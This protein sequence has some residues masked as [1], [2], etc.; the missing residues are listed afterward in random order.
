M[1]AERQDPG[2]P[3]DPGDPTQGAALGDEP[4]GPAAGPAPHVW[5]YW[6]D[7]PGRGCPAYLLLVPRDRPAPPGRDKTL[8][9]L[10]EH[11]VF[12]WLPDLD[13]KVWER[14][15]VPAQRADYARTRLVYRYGGLWIDA[16][17]IAMRRLDALDHYLDGHELASW[18]KDIRGR[19]FNNLF[20]AP[21]GSTLVGRWIEN[22]DRVLAGCE[23]WNT[24]GWNDIG[25]GAFFPLM[26]EADY[27]NMPAPE[28]APVLWFAWR[29][30][31]SPYQSPATSPG[32]VAGHGDAVEQGH[33]ARCSPAKS[34]D[35]VLGAPMLLSRLLRIALGTSTLEAELDWRTR[36]S[37]VSDLRYGPTGRSI[38][39]RLRR[40]R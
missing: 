3:P 5:M 37:P 17:C 15:K 10:D 31:L 24:L 21:A 13:R 7:L 34:S 40:L 28:V 26:R 29:R 36:L 30:F 16:D 8:H 18:G 4:A 14:L 2:G 25:S 39:R 11:S 32:L 38:E 9:V 22:Q 23:D 12:D 6:E 33:G 20:S 27:A 19:F 1:A 35:E